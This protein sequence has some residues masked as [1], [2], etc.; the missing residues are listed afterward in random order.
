MTHLGI[1]IMVRNASLSHK[2]YATI[3]NYSLTVSAE[4]YNIGGQ[5]NS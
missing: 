5:F 3:Y 4:N 1:Q 2:H